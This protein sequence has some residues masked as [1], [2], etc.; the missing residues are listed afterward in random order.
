MRSLRS[1]TWANY[2]IFLGL[3]VMYKDDRVIISQRKF[4][5]DLLK[6]YNCLDHSTC[7]SLLDPIVKL[8]AGEGTILQDPSYYKKLVGK[9]NFLTKLIFLTNI[10]MDITYSVQHLSQFLQEP[11]EPHLKATFHLL[12][13][14]RNDPTLRIFMSKDADCTVKAYCDSDW[15]VCPDSRRS[16]TSYL[17]LLGNSPISRKSKKY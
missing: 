16:I 1:K 5:L 12:R 10:R 14:L 4:V 6:E 9:L 11:R 8:K 17:V 3:K 7:S 2:I 13:Y 15:V